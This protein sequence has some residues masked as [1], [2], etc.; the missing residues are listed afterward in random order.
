LRKSKESKAIEPHL[1]AVDLFSA[2]EKK[3]QKQKGLTT[4]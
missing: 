3:T 1:F 4:F 2:I